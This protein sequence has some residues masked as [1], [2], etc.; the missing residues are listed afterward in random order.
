MTLPARLVAQV[1]TKAK[2]A[3][4]YPS[5]LGP[6]SRQ[7]ALRPSSLAASLSSR[8]AG[9]AVV[10]ASLFSSLALPLATAR[11]L[12]RMAGVQLQRNYSTRPTEAEF[13]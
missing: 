11:C 4:A 12:P 6:V 2:A 13:H 7:A 9:D 10:S 1:R 3:T 5:A 8:P